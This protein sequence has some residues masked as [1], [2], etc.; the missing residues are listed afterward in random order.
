[1]K[2]V[3]V[4][5]LLI[6]ACAQ[7][8]GPPGGGRDQAPPRIIATVPDTNAVTPNFND[9]VVFRFDETLSERGVREEDMVLVSPETGEV[10]VKRKGREIRVKIEGGWQSGRV[11]H[12]T[13]LPGLQ[14][15]H[16]NPRAQT[17]ELVFS[18]GPEIQATA[19]AGL[20][21]DHLTFR[22][23]TNAR[24]IA[25]SLADSATYLTLTDTAGFFALRSLPPGAYRTTAYID[26]N[27][28]RKLSGLEPR[29]EERVNLTAARDTP[30]VEL[31]VLALDTTPARL[32]RAEARD[33][34][35]MLLTFDD[36]I[37]ATEPLNTVTVSVFIMPDSTLLPRGSLLFPRDYDRLVQARMDT[38]AKAAPGRPVAAPTDTVRLPT[39]TLVWTPQGTLRPKTRYRVIVN[40]VRNIVG[41]AGGGGTTSF[42]TPARPPAAP[43]DSAAAKRTPADSAAAR[44]AARDTTPGQPAR[45]RR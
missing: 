40:G 15:R 34:L 20:V 19:I 31:S 12:V 35:H 39:Q 5:G 29:D 36:F 30:V 26:T 44:P 22:P 3:L 11:Y 24:V 28:D 14:D 2:R 16:G 38:T 8:S 6:G 10:E 9:E 4:L 42:E 45:P 1:M 21:K 27:R 43:A 18:T 37:A 32:L 13:L 7:A 33:S 41:L 25:T 17:Y 23:V